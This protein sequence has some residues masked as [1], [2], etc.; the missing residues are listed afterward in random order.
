MS[1]PVFLHEHDE[2]PAA[3]GIVSAERG[4]GEALVEKDYW[5]THTLWALEQAGL[6][7]SLKGGTSL[8][9]GFGLIQ[10]FSEDLDVKIG[11]EGLP[12]V[13]D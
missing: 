4:V 3:L 5:I 9:K 11:G 1:A 6:V 10:R 12:A 7:V 2:F 13:T 8:S